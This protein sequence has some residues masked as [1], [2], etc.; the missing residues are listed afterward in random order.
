MAASS[1][2]H[3]N[4][5]PSAQ[6]RC[7]STASLRETATTARRIPRL[8]ATAMPQARSVDQRWLRVRRAKDA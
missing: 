4:S 7:I 3:R 5:V 2:V 8:L 1:F 6:M